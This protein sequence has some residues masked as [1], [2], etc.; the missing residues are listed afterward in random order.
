MSFW[1]S[2]GCFAW[3]LYKK[4]VSTDNIPGLQG[5]LIATIG[6]QNSNNLN[7]S[8]SVLAGFEFPDQASFNAV[9]STTIGSS[10]S[11]FKK[12]ETS[13]A[14]TQSILKTT[15]LKFF[16]CMATFQVKDAKTTRLFFV[17]PMSVRIFKM[18]ITLTRYYVSAQRYFSILYFSQPYF[19]KKSMVKGGS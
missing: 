2:L 10:L 13:E 3:C 9:S 4:T 16:L 17:G 12:S 15:R 18:Q 11:D 14:K 6:V 19:S 8:S 1:D 5:A 7:S